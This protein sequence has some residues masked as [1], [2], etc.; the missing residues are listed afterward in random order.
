MVRSLGGDGPM[1]FHLQKKLWSYD[2][3]LLLWTSETAVALGRLVKAV[4]PF[5][6]HTL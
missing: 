1:N 3:W 6:L 4:E 2:Q 5:P